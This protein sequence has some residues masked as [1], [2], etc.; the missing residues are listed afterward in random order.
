MARLLRMEPREEEVEG[1]SGS[2]SCI[3]VLCALNK[4]KRVPHPHQTGALFWQMLFVLSP[5]VKHTVGKR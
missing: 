3:L 2:E 4:A 5:I 1:G